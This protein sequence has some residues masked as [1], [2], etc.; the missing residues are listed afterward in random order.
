MRNDPCFSCPLSECDDTSTRCAMR[1]LRNSY[2]AKLRR[3]QKE[4]VTD[5]ERA[6]NNF[7]FKIFNLE[8]CAEAAE[9]IR[10]YERWERLSAARRYPEQQRGEL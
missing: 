4:L 5:Q 9:G 1:R 3:G 6:A 2:F 8:R 7:M 10:P